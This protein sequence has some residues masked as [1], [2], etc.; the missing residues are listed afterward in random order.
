MKAN[1]IHWRNASQEMLWLGL[2]LECIILTIAFFYSPKNKNP[3][4]AFFCETVTY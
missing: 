1:Y 2:I 3:K 4:E